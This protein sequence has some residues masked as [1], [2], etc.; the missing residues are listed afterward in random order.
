MSGVFKWTINRRGQ[1]I[2]GVMH[3]KSWNS[4]NVEKSP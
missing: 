2:A 1:V 4:V 3:I